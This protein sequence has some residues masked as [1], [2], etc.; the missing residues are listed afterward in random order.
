MLS[1]HNAQV[2]T[3]LLGDPEAGGRRQAALGADLYAQAKEKFDAVA[4]QKR[5]TAAQIAKYTKLLATLNAQQR[6]A[7]AGADQPDGDPDLDQ[8]GQ[9]GRQPA[10]DISGQV[11]TAVKFALAQVGKPYVWGQAGPSSYDCSGLTMAAYH[12]AGINLPHSAAEPVQLRP[13]RAATAICS[14][15]T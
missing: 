13:P 11:R 1:S 9:A 3:L 5:Q 4:A 10:G 15:A 12:A 8:P 14:P 6:A 7:W 2:V